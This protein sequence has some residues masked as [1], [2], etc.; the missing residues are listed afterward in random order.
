MKSVNQS[1]SISDKQRARYGNTWA[2][3]DFIF[4]DKISETSY[5]ED[6]M[7][8]NIGV[9]HVAGTAIPMTYKDMLAVSKTATEAS[10]KT[11]KMPR[12]E[13]FAIRI[14]SYTILLR[15]IEINRLCETMDDA[16][17]TS[18]RGYELGLY[19]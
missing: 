2:D 19:L 3:L 15:P 7:N 18:Q 10:A 4:A 8:T 9:L 12:E 6:L 1:W 11:Y 13:K 16:L 17:I 5:R 14:K